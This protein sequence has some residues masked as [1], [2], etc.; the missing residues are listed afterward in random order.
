MAE[1][2][3]STPKAPDFS[4]T[5]VRYSANV[6]SASPFLS[7]PDFTVA[8]LAILPVAAVTVVSCRSARGAVVCTRV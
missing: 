3:G 4:R 6:S 7:R 8:V 2:D 5:I 1:G